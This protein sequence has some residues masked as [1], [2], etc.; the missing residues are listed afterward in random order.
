MGDNVLTKADI[1]DVVQEKMGLPRTAAARVVDDLFEII[2]DA[3]ARGES[4]KISGLGNFEVRKKKE[5][6][7]RN[8]QTGDDMTIEART[9]LTFKPSQSIRKSLRNET[10]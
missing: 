3:L 10:G 5:R 4:V 6:R 8:P 7:G 1:I 9:V 2:K